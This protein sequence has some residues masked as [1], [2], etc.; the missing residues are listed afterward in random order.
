M[1]SRG[2]WVLLGSRKLYF[3]HS[4]EPGGFRAQEER[5]AFLHAGGSAGARADSGP[6]EPE[7]SPED[8]P[9]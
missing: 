2:Q 7:G 6:C 9:V 4:R 1:A 3:K 8:A 5:D